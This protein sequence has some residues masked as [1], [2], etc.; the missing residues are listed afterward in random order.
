MNTAFNLGQ[1][2]KHAATN[3]K[4]RVARQPSEDIDGDSLIALDAIEHKKE[5]MNRTSGSGYF[6]PRHLI[7]AK[8]LIPQIR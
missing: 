4:Y 7:R 2:V 3:E 8:N 6:H 5:F 1:I